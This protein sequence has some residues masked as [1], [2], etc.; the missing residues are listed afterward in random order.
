[1]AKNKKSYFRL[2]LTKV[3]Y[4][5][6]V[7]GIVLIV[8]GYLLMAG[9]RPPSPDEF[10]PQD[11]YHWRR[12]TLAPVMIVAGFMLQ[13]VAIFYRRKRASEQ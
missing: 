13:F 6:G 9:G 8:A 10:N 3:N 5:I 7:A 2:D 12:I 4:L 1:M 11:I